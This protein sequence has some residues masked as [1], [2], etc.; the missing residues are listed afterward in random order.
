MV[1]LH[2]GITSSFTEGMSYQDVI[3]SAINAKDGHDVVFISDCTKFVGGKL[4]ETDE[5]DIVTKGGLRLIRLKYDMIIN[6]FV[7]SKFRKIKRLYSTI[8]DINPDVILFH[9]AAAFEII[10]VAKYVR[11]N[12]NV[13]L[14]VDSHEDKNNSGTNWLSLNILHKLF[15]RWCNRKALKDINKIFYI[16]EE[17]KDFLIDIYKLPE[18]KMEFYP[19]GGIIFSENDRLM[20]MQ[21]KRKELNLNKDDI[22]FVH[23]GKMDKLKRTVDIIKA[24]SSVKS[25]KL[26][27]VIIGSIT[28]DVKEVLIPMINADNRIKYLGWKSSDELMKYL[29]ASDLYVQPGGQSATMQNAICCGSPV[30]LY[31]H[32][33]HKVYIKENGYF[34]ESIE[35]MANVFNDILNNPS[36][37]EKMRN[38]S[39]KIAFDL[40]DYKKL[41]A[42]LYE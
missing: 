28:D 10:N 29:C 35:D 21:E 40:L 15:Y 13:K 5:E 18:E 30:A 37:I 27:L 11:K 31:P 38:N 19:L 25:D 26:K 4:V 36:K 20:Y 1:I 3:L 14:Y 6:K 16:S 9:G 22:L 7:S 24:F 2:I 12:S 41:A 34:I 33:S 17:T 42:R 23:S 32:K 39:I 8:E